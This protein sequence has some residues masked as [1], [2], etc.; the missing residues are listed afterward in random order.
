MI[1]IFRFTYKEVKTYAYMFNV[2]ATITVGGGASAEA[3]RR[4]KRLKASKVLLVTDSFM[5]DYGLGGK[6]M[7]AIKKEGVEIGLFSHVNPDP[8]D[9]NVREGLATFKKASCQKVVGVGGR[10]SWTDGK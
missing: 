3:G 1:Q 5:V 6:V 4:A 10:S 7:D 9:Q 8:T 2:P